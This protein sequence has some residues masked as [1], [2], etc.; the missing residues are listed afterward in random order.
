MFVEFF[1]ANVELLRK[2]KY[3]STKYSENCT[4]INFCKK[5]ASIIN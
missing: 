4:K 5:T 3:K 1:F 2:D